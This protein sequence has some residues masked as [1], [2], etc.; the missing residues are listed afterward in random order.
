MNAAHPDIPNA[1]GIAYLIAWALLALTGWRVIATRP[2]AALKKKWDTRFSLLGIIVVCGSMVTALLY[3]RQVLAAACLIPV[4]IGL[5]WY[6][7]R[8]THFCP[9]CGRR[10]AP[11][12]F[13]P[14]EY[15]PKCGAKLR[16]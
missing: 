4:A 2:T 15:C 16:E 5:A 12:L 8:N 13:T 7:I 1:Y 14:I 11:Q 3:A 6:S 10:V 9:R